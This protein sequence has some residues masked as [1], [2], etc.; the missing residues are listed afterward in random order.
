MVIIF[1]FKNYDHF[2]NEISRVQMKQI[3]LLTNSQDCVKIR[4]ILH[5]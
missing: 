3:L 1:V 5:A 4:C 2:V